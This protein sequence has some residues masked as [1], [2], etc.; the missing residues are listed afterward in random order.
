M[1]ERSIGPI[2]KKASRGFPVLLLEGM[3]QVGKSWIMEQLAGPERRYIS[4]D[5]L[6]LRSFA[7]N[8]PKGFIAEYKPPVIIDEVQY[9]PQIFTYI[10]IEVDKRKQDGLYWLTGSQQYRLMKG[11]QESLAGRVAILDLMGLSWKEIN[12]HADAAKP[13]LPSMRKSTRALNLTDVYTA[14]WK[15]S[16]PRPLDNP[17]TDREQFYNSYL[18][19]YI[20]RDVKDFEGVS[21]SLAFYDF[22]RSIAARTANLLNYTELA[23]DVGVD[24]KTIRRW[25]SLLDRS[26]IVRLLEPYAANLSERIIKAPKLYFLDTGLASYLCGWDSPKSLA[27]GAQ[28]GSMLETWVF[29]EI[30]KSY[31][32]AGRSPQIFF[33]RDKDKKEIDFVI[34]QNM[35]LYPLE[36]KRSAS[37][38]QNDIKNFTILEKFC[39]NG[40]KLGLGAVLDLNSLVVPIAKNVLSIPVW[41]I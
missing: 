33:Y 3:R 23:R 22:I 16:F 1:F 15:G 32:H 38:T 2:I 11:V 25:L 40:R 26:G 8:D 10:K 30:L 7:Q 9:A 36:V 4:L 27:L 37:P 12:G 18:R 21:N 29:C 14:I 20:E 13:F 28:N 34:E 39:K 17:D 41:E 31:Y 35:T 5:D 6:D 24:V 19:T